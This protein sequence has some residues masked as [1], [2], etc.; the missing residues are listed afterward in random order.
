MCIDTD[1]VGIYW[2]IDSNKNPK[3]QYVINLTSDYQEIAM[4]FDVLKL[5]KLSVNY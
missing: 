4:S 3:E 5:Y 2:Y 1:N